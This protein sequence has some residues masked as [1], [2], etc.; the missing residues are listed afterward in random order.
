MSANDCR[1]A[2]FLKTPPT[3]SLRPLADVHDEIVFY[4]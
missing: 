4:L 3:G 1:T 2:T